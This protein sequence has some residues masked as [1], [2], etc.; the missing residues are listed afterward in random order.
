MAKKCSWCG[1]DLGMDAVVRAHTEGV[2]CSWECVDKSDNDRYGT[3]GITSVRCAECGRGFSP[4]DSRMAER[5]TSNVFHSHCT[6]VRAQREEII[7]LRAE[8]DRLR[9]SL[10]VTVTIGG[11]P[12]EISPM[13]RQQ[14]LEM[15]ERKMAR[16]K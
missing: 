15:A 13:M 11:S 16:A 8:C 14:L 10:P 4:R 9:A 5:G 1:C 7:A 12:V 3:T 6:V 2:Y